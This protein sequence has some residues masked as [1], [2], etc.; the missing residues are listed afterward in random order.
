MSFISLTDLTHPVGAIYLSTASTSPASLFGGSWSQI[1]SRFLYATTSS[2]WT[3]GSNTHTLS[4]SEMPS[5]THSTSVILNSLGDTGEVLWQH[6]SARL[7]AGGVANTGGGGL[8][9]TCPHTMPVTVG[10]GLPKAGV[11]A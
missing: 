8:T 3:G 7:K 9:T 5:H 1:T 6:G 11:A 2:N 10:E 4:V